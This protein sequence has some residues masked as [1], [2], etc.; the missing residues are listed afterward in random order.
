MMV[1]PV[2]RGNDTEMQHDDEIVALHINGGKGS[3]YV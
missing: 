1:E 2:T 3:T